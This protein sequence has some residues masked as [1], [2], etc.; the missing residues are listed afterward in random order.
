MS[1]VATS[2][3][4]TRPELAD[5]LVRHTTSRRAQRRRR[6][7]IVWAARAVILG[8]VLGAWQSY[9]SSSDY[10]NFVI[11]TPTDTFAI[12]RRYLTERQWWRDVWLTVQEAGLGYLLGI[13][14]ALLLVGVITPLPAVY[15]FLSPFLAALNALP[16]IVLAPLFI[17]WFGLT[18]NGKVYFVSAAIF[19]VIFYGVHTG[20]RSIDVDIVNNARML[21]SSRVQ[22]IRTVY[23]PAVATWLLNSLRVSAALSLL[24]AVVAEYLGS[25]A[26]IGFRIAKARSVLRVDMVL[27][28]IVFIATMALVLDRILVRIQRRFD[29]WRVF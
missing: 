10:R 19:F 18:M 28:G 20:L 2:L 8:A 9:G 22:L 25:Q 12:L 7:T 24:A 14:A 21:G 5:A 27:A 4:A 15:R 23:A 29:R 3:P 1:S 13:L 16:K 6:T 17:L 11:S 26:G